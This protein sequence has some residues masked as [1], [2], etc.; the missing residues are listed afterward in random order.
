MK[1]ITL[2]IIFFCAGSLM[3]QEENYSIKN[4][5]VNTKYQDFGTTFYKDSLIVFA[6]T[7]NKRSIRKNLW[8]G[9]KQPFLELFKG[10]FGENGEITN[11]DK[12][13]KTIN[14][15]YHDASVT[16]TKDFK[17]VY[18][19]R[20]NYLNKKFKKDSTGWNLNQLYKA[21]V[22]ENGK[23]TNIVPM[24]FNSDNYQTGH[25]VL[26][27]EE[28][29]LYFI[30]DMPGTIGKTD[31]FIVDVYEDG[32]YGTPKNL[33][34]N[35]NTTKKE[36]FPF[37]DENNVLYFSSDGYSDGLGGLDIYAIQVVN[38]KI[39]DV[40][41]NIGSPM[42]SNQDDFGIVYQQGKRTGYFSSNRDGGK[43]DDDIYFFKELKPIDFKCTQFVEGIVVNT[44]TGAV[45][46]GALV[47]LYNEQGIR[48]NSLIADDLG[49][50]KFEAICESTYKI[51][52]SK[53]E[54]SNDQ[55]VFKTSKEH[56]LEHDL[57]L[58]LSPKEFISI[59]GE[60]AINI[61]QIYFDL[62][63][64]FIRKDAAIELNQ[65]LILMNKYPELIIELG[66][67][68]DSRAPDSY[69]LKLS[70]R[71]V[72][73][74]VKWIVDHGIDAKRISGKGYGETQLVNECSNGVKCTEEEHQLNRRTEFIIVN[75]KVIK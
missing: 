34:L 39:V 22:D 71:R 59:G 43:G 55:I 25:P 60:L 62:D 14:S 68:T 46:P 38:N 3:A 19:T 17:T 41:I 64:S 65:V 63:K 28:D 70:E 74:T 35:V 27:K 50:F 15:K 48:I 18:F 12:F 69:N 42:N 1:K 7:R 47:D 32:T 21:Q 66:S 58:S 37:L 13:S 61:P 20:N 45:I 10:K 56:N 24:P 67:H 44:E 30:S 5:D 31:I 6:S 29:K 4:L 2:I 75:S 49:V 33:G 73:S 9:N 23:W 52:V 11:V 51:I 53:E 40:S 26:N 8:L 57:K 16:F 72:K 54:Y 36:M